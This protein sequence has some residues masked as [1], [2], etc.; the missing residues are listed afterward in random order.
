MESL[1]KTSSPT[2]IKLINDKLAALEARKAAISDEI[3]GLKIASSVAITEDDVIRWLRSFCKGDSADYEFRKQIIDVLINSI[4]VF[5]DK[6][7]FFF[8]VQGGKQVSFVD[9]LDVLPP[10]TCSDFGCSGVPNLDLSELL[11]CMPGVVG[12]VIQRGQ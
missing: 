2:A 10:E 3:A 11:I 1:I 4:Y 8:N 6:I 12:C 5:D 7:V 9:M